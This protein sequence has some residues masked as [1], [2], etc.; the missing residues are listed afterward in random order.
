MIKPET[1]NL[2]RDL[3]IGSSSTSPS[4]GTKITIL[5]YGNP[6]THCFTLKNI[7]LYLFGRTSYQEFQFRAPR[8]GKFPKATPL[9]ATGTERLCQNETMPLMGINFAVHTVDPCSGTQE[10]TSHHTANQLDNCFVFVTPLMATSMATATTVQMK[11]SNPQ[12][13][14]PPKTMSM[15][16]GLLMTLPAS[17]N[18]HPNARAVMRQRFFHQVPPSYC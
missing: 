11:L 17:P 12:Q 9:H 15:L 2:T 13:E 8:P 18:L 1:L 14:G 4:S 5:A 3:H 7:F 16:V 6:P 10:S